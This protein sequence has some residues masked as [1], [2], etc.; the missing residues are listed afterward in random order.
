M[1]DANTNTT[2]TT[3]AA[4]AKVSDVKQVETAAVQAE[5]GVLAWF[6]TLTTVQ[7]VAVLVVAAVVVTALVHF[8]L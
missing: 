6:K 5:T 3:T 1:A 7:K 4:P 8:F 2:A